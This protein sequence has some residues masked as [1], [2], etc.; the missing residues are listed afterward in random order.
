MLTSCD[1]PISIF[2]AADTAESVRGDGREL[3]AS[4]A[5]AGCVRPMR[6]SCHGAAAWFVM[7]LVI[8]VGGSGHS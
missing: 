4:S 6:L 2:R 7:I 8:V 3:T 5:A 1:R